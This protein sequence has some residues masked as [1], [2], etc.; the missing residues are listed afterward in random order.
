MCSKNP[1]VGTLFAQFITKVFLIQEFPSMKERWNNDCL[2]VY[3]DTFADARSKQKHGYD[4]NDYEYGIFP[5]QAGTSCCVYRAHLVDQQLG[6]GTEAPR[7]NTV[8]EDIP[9][10]FIKKA[11]GYTYRI[12]FPAKYLLPAK[13]RKGYIVGFG[14]FVPNVDDSAAKD[15]KRMTSALTLAEDGNGCFNR[16]HQWPLMLLWE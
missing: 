4:E 11:D 5:N 8:A 16:P 2:Q 14:L 6:L 1:E 3:I 10:S 7:K 9:S 12:F 15:S 13:M